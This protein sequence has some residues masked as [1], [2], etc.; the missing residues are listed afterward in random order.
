MKT[1]KYII[2][3]IAFSC[4]G[5]A[6]ASSDFPNR[7]IRMVVPTSAGGG[8]DV[9]ARLVAEGM[10]KS[11]GQPI[12]IENNAGAS[13]TIATRSVSMA[14]PDGYTIGLG[15]NS[16]MTL[17]PAVFDKLPYD[18]RKDLSTIARIATAPIVLV[19][20]NDFPAN[21]FKEII[22]QAKG[23]KEPLMYS[24]YGLGSMGHLC[25][26]VLARKANI[27]LSHVPYKGTAAVLNGLLSGDV[28]LGWM[29]LATGTT[30]VGTGKIKPVGLCARPTGRF[31]D[32]ATLKD[33]GIDFDQWSGFSLIGPA[34]LPKDIVDKISN[35]VKDAINEKHIADMIRSWGM[36]PDHMHGDEHAAINSVDID[37]WKKIAEDANVKP[38]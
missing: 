3:A 21:S 2:A 22:A 18:P 27:K 31:P 12:T 15:L 24:S 6:H 11:L 29:D 9:L 37:V 10:R 13:G 33:E 8:G 32:T 25:G 23:A 4:S 17:A 36:T 30:A 1:L 26:E 14:A 20:V 38:E 7:P 35:A 34:N 16:T 28:K 5:G 19:A